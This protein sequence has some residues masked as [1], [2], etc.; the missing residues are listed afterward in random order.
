MKVLITL[1]AAVVI[2]ALLVTFL[3]LISDALLILLFDKE[4]SDVIRE[5]RKRRAKGDSHG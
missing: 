3:A 5:Q 4:L 2:I 1:A